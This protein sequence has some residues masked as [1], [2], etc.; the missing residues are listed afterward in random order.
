MKKKTQ[1]ASSLYSMEQWKE[2]I[3]DWE[4]SGVSI[5]AY[6]IRKRL[7]TSNFYR[8]K[9]KIEYSLSSKLSPCANKTS[10]PE[11]ENLL[12]DF[13][14]SV[15]KEADAPLIPFPVNQKLEI[16]FAQGH[17]LC[18]NGPFDWEK[19]SFWLA[20]LLTDSSKELLENMDYY[21]NKNE[22]P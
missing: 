4:K 13:F 22:L 11:L 21:D 17:R 12:Q 9:K 18:L 20:P 5:N 15:P 16:V 10:S 3:T 2:I 14:V 8:W 19:L 6:C 1:Q 7:S